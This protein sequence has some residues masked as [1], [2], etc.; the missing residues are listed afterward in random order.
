MTLES[1]GY[2][3]NNPNKER[4][5]FKKEDNFGVS[6]LVFDKHFKE[7]EMYYVGRLDNKMSFEILTPS[8]VKA[9]YREMEDMEWIE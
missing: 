4:V 2:I 5:I 9:I 6:T 7:L 8:I 1:L 3:K